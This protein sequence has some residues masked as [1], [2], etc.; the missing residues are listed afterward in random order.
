[1]AKEALPPGVLLSSKTT[2]GGTLSMTHFAVSPGWIVRLSG[3]NTSC[4]VSDPI[5][6][7]KFA[8][9]AGGATARLATPTRRT[10]ARFLRAEIRLAMFAAV[11]GRFFD[12]GIVFRKEIADGCRLS[13]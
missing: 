2:L 9:T 7:V 6:K 11:K 10:I 3:T 4:S 1:M 5:W 12:K 8:A 13:R